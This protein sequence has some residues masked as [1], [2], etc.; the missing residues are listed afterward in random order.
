MGNILVSGLSGFVG[1]NLKS[2][3][4]NF[5]KQVRGYSLKSAVLPD[6]K[7]IDSIVHLAGKAHDLKNVSNPKEYYQVNFELTRDLYT[8]FLK[9]NVKKFIF[10]SSVKASADIVEGVLLESDQPNPQTHYGKSKLMA[11]QFIQSQTLPDG[12]SYYILRPCMIHG[13]GNK[14]NLN[15]LFQF[16]SK[17]I[18][19]P[20]AAFENKRSFLSVENLCFVIRE[21]IEREDIPSGVY[22]VAD[23]EALSTNELVRLIGKESK[24]TARLWKIS[25]SLIKTLAL[26]GDKFKLPLTTERLNKLVENYLV[27]NQKL[28]DVIQKDLPVAAREGIINT[29]RSFRTNSS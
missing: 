13:P 25:P 27:S 5:G 6:L 1:I 2:Y 18:P 15:L 12:K 3:F 11:E 10:I 17:G 28:R 21:I 14:G 7:D 29:I 20:L 4:A 24:R 16:V 8:A 23:D 19:Y 26:L 9:S 22:Q